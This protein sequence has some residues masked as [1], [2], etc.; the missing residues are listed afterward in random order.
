MARQVLSLAGDPA[1]SGNER[2]VESG[3]EFANQFLTAEWMKA[4][5]EPNFRARTP[6][7]DE[8]A[9]RIRFVAAWWEQAVR[10]LLDSDTPP[11]YNLDEAGA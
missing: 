1:K 10:G 4:F 7:E 5:G 2:F 11:V 8:V 6:S 3:V 9:C